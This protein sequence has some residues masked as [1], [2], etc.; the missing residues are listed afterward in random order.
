MDSTGDIGSYTSLALDSSGNPH[1]SYHDSTNRDLKYARFDG[2]SWEIETVDSMGDV[3]NYVSIALDN[4]DNVHI[5]YFDA[6]NFDLKY[7]HGCASDSDCD[8]VF[9]SNDNCPKSPNPGQRT[10]IMTPLGMP[11]T[12]AQMITTLGKRIQMKMV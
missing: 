7:A 2:S 12:I 10:M 4:S 5:S 9:D 3:G 6:S 1:I 8:G 11:V